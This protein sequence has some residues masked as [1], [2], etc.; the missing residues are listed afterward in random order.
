MSKAS[1]L[2]SS[3][4]T[5]TGWQ[6]L[7]DSLV[8]DTLAELH[9]LEKSGILYVSRKGVRKQVYIKD[10]LPIAARSNLKAELIGE[11]LVAKGAITRSQQ[12]RAIE[13]Q[14]K[15]TKSF[16]AILM[17]ET[18]LD[19]DTL[20]T[21]ARRQF[22]TILFSLFGLREGFFKFEEVDLPKDIYTYNVAFSNLITFGIRQISDPR[23]VKEI[24]GDFSQ[25]PSQTASFSEYES[26]MCTEKELAV[27]HAI[28]GE[29]TIQE[30]FNATQ[31]KL[32]LC[33]K[34]LLLLKYHGHI[35]FHVS[36][37]DGEIDQIIDLEEP[38]ASSFGFS[39]YQTENF[40]EEAAI[41]GSDFLGAP[42]SV[43]TALEEKAAR[44]RIAEESLAEKTEGS[45][46]T[47]GGMAAGEE[48]GINGN[49][50]D[51]QL[52][53]ILTMLHREK[54]TGVL[55]ISREKVKKH[56]YIQDGVPISA[57]SNMKSEL[58]GEFLVARDVITKRDQQRTLELLENGGKSFGAVLLEQ[59][60][61]GGKELFTNGR[62]QFLTI[63]FSLFGLNHGF[64]KFKEE[65]LP[66]SIY[67]YKVN[68]PDL[69]TLGIRQLSD[70]KVIRTMVGESNRVVVPAARFSEWKDIKLTDDEKE[71]LQFV[72]GKGTIDEIRNAAKADE[73]TVL[74]TLLIMQLTDY[75]DFQVDGSGDEK[76]KIVEME[77]AVAAALGFNS[78]DSEDTAEES[79]VAGTDFMMA[80]ESL[81]PTAPA[82][83]EGAAA[84]MDE[85]PSEF[86]Q[87]DETGIPEPR[88]FETQESLPSFEMPVSAE[89]EC[90]AE[91]MEAPEAPAALHKPSGPRTIAIDFAPS[92]EMELHPDEAM[93]D[94]GGT[95]RSNMAMGGSAF[96]EGTAALQTAAYD[97]DIEAPSASP[98]TT[99]SPQDAEIA[100]DQDEG[101]GDVEFGSREPVELTQEPVL[102]EMKEQVPEDTNQLFQKEL[103][104]A[105][106]EKMAAMKAG[107]ADTE[108]PQTGGTDDGAAAEDTEAAPSVFLQHLNKKEETA[109]AKGSK[110]AL[111]RAGR[112]GRKKVG[113]GYAASLLLIIG[114]GVLAV[115][116]WGADLQEKLLASL[117]DSEDILQTGETIQEGKSSYEVA[118]V[119]MDGVASRHKLPQ[120]DQTAAVTKGEQ[121][122]SPVNAAPPTVKETVDAGAQAAKT[123]DPS[124]SAA[125]SEKNTAVTP[126]PAKPTVK[127]VDPIQASPSKTA[128]TA[129]PIKV[130]P[131]REES[132][133]KQATSF[134]VIKAE[135]TAVP[136][137][138]PKVGSSAPVVKEPKTVV[139]KTA[140]RAQT[141]APGAP[142]AAATGEFSSQMAEWT[143]QLKAIPATRYTIQVEISSNLETVRRDLAVLGSGFDA[144]VVPYQVGSW[145][146][147]TLVV[148]V[149]NSRQEGNEALPNLPKHILN[150]KPLVKTMRTIQKGLMVSD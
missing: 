59:D 43:R 10:G 41:A 62:R 125:V 149:F 55:F 114:L 73:A 85:R 76:D 127:P 58:L 29:K 70:T 136:P 111:K 57:R 52:P 94:A 128:A 2:H 146:A 80:P 25:I 72:N 148:G 121:Q 3:S 48:T 106:Q 28:D 17:E 30:I 45:Q 130:K 31:V 34:T 18:M 20:F 65:D 93:E 7:R 83:L 79:A 122:K 19:K 120:S 90:P 46:E 68:F 64:Y 22:L 135:K 145:K 143:R 47:V 75:V 139:A 23:L 147:Y 51:R 13:L 123:S 84:A 74:K 66:E 53:G 21:H 82:S 112:Q 115:S 137:A 40:D 11:F 16:G 141:P 108:L 35:E 36:F 134:P 102:D 117:S 15:F 24:V 61:I 110:T 27:V 95:E 77:Q 42:E 99:E 129:S 49:L 103:H 138:T 56:I 109:A 6:D 116:P 105:L 37:E 71:V 44:Q 60:L 119:D 38:A 5:A 144:K 86:L 87:D 78:Y 26:L 63:L 91:D 81:D 142:Q 50:K 101:N 131:L 126:K 133:G 33:L 150:Q 98:F 32:L 132:P 88:G 39:T 1:I 9:R 100:G 104:E 54:K 107:E 124:K 140:T 89:A 113:L 12:Q 14:K 4:E 96:E 67:C 97:L 118:A 8:P 92:E 69:I